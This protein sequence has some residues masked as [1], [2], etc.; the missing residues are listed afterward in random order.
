MTN[1]P[2]TTRLCGSLIVG[3]FAGPTLPSNY[4]QA[5]AEGRRGGAIL[6]RQN[7]PE[8]GQLH[9][10]CRAVVE[11]AAPTGEPAWLGVDEEGGRVRRLPAPALAL[12]PA[13]LLGGPGAEPLAERAGDA[14][15]AQLAALGFNVDFAPVLDVDTNPSNPVIGAR[16]FAAEPEAVTR[17]A[18]AL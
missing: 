16:A 18:G 10:L 13:R 2:A 1:A 4:A 14:L 7:M 17:L 11:A 6:F 15:G 5:L 8:L 9:A 12:P 3:A